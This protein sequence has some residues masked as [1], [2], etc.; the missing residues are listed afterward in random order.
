MVQKGVL[1]LCLSFCVRGVEIS[2]TRLVHQLHGQTD[3]LL[4]H[5]V[6]FDNLNHLQQGR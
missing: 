4:S 6:S 3:A 1:Y 2:A 5:I